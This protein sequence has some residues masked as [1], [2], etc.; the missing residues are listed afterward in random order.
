MTSRVLPTTRRALLCAFAALLCAAAVGQGMG[1]EMFGT[2]PSFGMSAPTTTR[3][4][5]MG[6]PLSC[7][8]DLQFSN[9]AFAPLHTTPNSG[10]RTIT[11]GFDNGPRLTSV[12]I[13]SVHPLRHDQGTVQITVLSLTSSGGSMTL[14]PMGPVTARMA[15]RTFVMDWGQRLTPGITAGLSIL[16]RERDALRF[17]S[18]AGPTLLDLSARAD[19]GFRGGLAW[20][21]APGDF[22]GF[23]G[24]YSQ[25]S[26]FT[27]GLA[28][29]SPGTTVFH[30][31]QVALGASHHFTDRL[32]GLIEY[33][34]GRTQSAAYASNR[35]ILRLGAQYLPA[36]GWALRAGLNDQSPTFGL[37]YEDGRWR[38]DYAFARDW[39]D[40]A[41]RPLFGG[42]DSHALQVI[43][44]W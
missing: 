24:S 30:S 3:Q 11:T 25:Q 40:D 23:T 6:N 1:P 7:V 44:N 39:N 22:I 16:G 10:V 18:L 43:Y 19:F 4:F 37:G 28:A 8:D 9:P 14:A 13:H 17:T 34:H 33:E 12:Q 2:V 20:E 26:V 29:S 15:E 21:W 31:S 36:R 27:S 42:S 41:A 38:A 32:L 5:S 35:N